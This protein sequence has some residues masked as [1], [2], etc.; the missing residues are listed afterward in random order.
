MSVNEGAQQTLGAPT[1]P[2]VAT[3]ELCFCFAECQQAARCVEPNTKRGDKE[4]NYQS[5]NKLERN[6]ACSEPTIKRERHASCMKGGEAPRATR[7][8]KPKQLPADYKMN[9]LFLVIFTKC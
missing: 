1:A 9:S 2:T 4:N 7:G 8:Y 5:S 6:R 3:A